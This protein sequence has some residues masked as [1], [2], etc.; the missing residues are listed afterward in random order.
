MT[1]LVATLLLLLLPAACASM[2]AIDLGSEYLKCTLITPGKVPISIVLNEFSKRKSPSL[3]GFANGERLLGE[4]AVSMAV[5][6][7]DTSIARARDLLGKAGDCPTVQSMLEQ[8]VFSWQM[9][10]KL[11]GP[12]SPS[13]RP[14]TLPTLILQRSMHTRRQ[15]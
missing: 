2:V 14:A 6:F 12:G 15:L 11:G 4:E 5:R 3:V 1:P 7:P 9:L 13:F 8:H 10:R